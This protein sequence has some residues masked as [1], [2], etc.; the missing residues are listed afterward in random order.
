MRTLIVYDNCNKLIHDMIFD[1]FI[2]I[3]DP[4]N[5]VAD[6]SF[7]V[8]SQLVHKIWQL[9]IFPVMADP[10]WPPRLKYHVFRMAPSLIFVFI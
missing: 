1:V 2:V 5:L 6:A 10:K 9:I 8:K 3:L 4:E 7:N